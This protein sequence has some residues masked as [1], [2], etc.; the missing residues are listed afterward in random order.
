MKTVFLRVPLLVLAISG[1]AIGAED[2]LP[3][4]VPIFRGNNAPEPAVAAEAPVPATTNA[5]P[6]QPTVKVVQAPAPPDDIKPS[7]G[8][9]EVIK[10]VQAGV[11]EEVTR[12]YVS[13]SLQPFNVSSDQIVYLNDLGVSTDLI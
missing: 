7:P 6:D 5:V 8:L 12:A 1:L 11:S 9:A 10:L 2:K 3:E 4:G 13:N